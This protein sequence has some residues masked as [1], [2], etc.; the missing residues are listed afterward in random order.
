MASLDAFVDHEAAFLRYLEGQEADT[1]ALSL[2]L[3]VRQVHS[4]HPKVSNAILRSLRY[5]RTYYNLMI[6]FALA[7]PPFLS[8]LHDTR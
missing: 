7:L 3:S 5:Y 8:F 2:G 6:Q 4:V 1:T